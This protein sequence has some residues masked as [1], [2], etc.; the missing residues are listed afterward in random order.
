MATHSAFA[1]VVVLLS[2][3]IGM[4]G[5]MRLEHMVWREA[6]LNS[7]MLLGGMGPVDKPN[8]ASGQIF[9]GCYALYC[10][11]MVLVV[12]AIVMAPVVHRFLHRF[13]WA[14]ERSR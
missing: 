12:I 6:F 11:L 13:H 9:A 5:Y 7:A 1:F 8:S 14:D 10:G 2:L 3:G 4:S